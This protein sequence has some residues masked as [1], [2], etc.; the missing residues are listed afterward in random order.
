MLEVGGGGINNTVKEMN[1]DKTHMK[2]CQPYNHQ[3]LLSKNLRSLGPKG[4]GWGGVAGVTE[5]YQLSACSQV[6]SSLPEGR[7]VCCM[8]GYSLVGLEDQR[9][10]SGPAPACREGKQKV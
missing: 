1:R 10:L 4:G 2:P 5:L 7:P 3:R 6:S 9:T 8:I